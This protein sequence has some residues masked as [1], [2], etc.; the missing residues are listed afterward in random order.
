MRIVRWSDFQKERFVRRD[1]ATVFQELSQGIVRYPFNNL[2]TE[3]QSGRWVFLKS[4]CLFEES[5]EKRGVT[6]STMR[7]ADAS[8]K[9]ERQPMSFWFFAKEKDG[10]RRIITAGIP[11]FPLIALILILILV[12]IRC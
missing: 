8:V 6:R 3:P 10:H 5:C 4:Q 12:L 11:I 7:V 2:I 9:R 1:E